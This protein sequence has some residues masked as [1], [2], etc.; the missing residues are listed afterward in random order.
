MLLKISYLK[1]VLQ[2]VSNSNS[3]ILHGY[4]LKEVLLYLDEY[5]NPSVQRYKT[6]VNEY[7]RKY[8]Q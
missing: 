7:Y 8:S 1:A 3:A 2:N 5:I 4:E 6:V